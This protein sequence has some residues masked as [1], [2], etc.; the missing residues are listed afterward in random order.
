MQMIQHLSQIHLPKSNPY[1][2]AWS[3]LQG[4]IGLY[5]KQ[6]SY[7]KQERVMSILSGLPLKLVD[8]FTYL[9]SNISSTESKVNMCSEDL[10]CY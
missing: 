10:Y 8:Q 3:R 5:M 6:S 2:T 9:S 1:Y 4:G 7:F